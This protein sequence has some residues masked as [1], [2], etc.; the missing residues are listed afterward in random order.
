MPFQLGKLCLLHVLHIVSLCTNCPPSPLRIVFLHLG[1]YYVCA[2]LPNR[3]SYK[4]F[5]HLNDAHVATLNPW[6]LVITPS[7]L[8]KRN[9]VMYQE[10]VGQVFGMWVFIRDFQLSRLW[11]C[12]YQAFL[13]LSYTLLAF[14]ISCIGLPD[15]KIAD[16]WC[17]DVFSSKCTHI[18]PYNS[19]CTAYLHAYRIQFCFS[20]DWP[21]DT[22]CS[23]RSYCMLVEMSSFARSSLL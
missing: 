2:R 1:I 14:M 7:N 3:M 6:V 13:S 11:L 17:K 10:R 15:T 22:T 4:H 23:P 18:L 8:Q 20:Q 5:K 21:M 9:L 19:A 12:P 16:L